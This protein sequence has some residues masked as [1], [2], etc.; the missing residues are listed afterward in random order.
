MGHKTRPNRSR[1]IKHIPYSLL[2]FLTISTIFATL[3]HLYHFDPEDHIPSPLPTSP[4]RP[5]TLP[6]TR[7]SIPTVDRK[8][9]YQ[10]CQNPSVYEH[11]QLHEEFC[12][13]RKELRTVNLQGWDST[14]KTFILTPENEQPREIHIDL[15]SLDTR[16]EIGYHLGL[17]TGNRVEY[18]RKHDYNYYFASTKL[19]N[20]RMLHPKFSKLAAVELLMNDQLEEKQWIVWMDNDILFTN[21][22]PRFEDLIEQYAHSETNLIITRDLR[23]DL[24]IINSGIFL[25]RNSAWSRTF[26][27]TIMNS[28]EARANS[29]LDEARLKDQPVIIKYLLKEGEIEDIREASIRINRHVSIITTRKMNSFC[30]PYI[31]YRWDDSSHSGSAIWHPGD[32]IAHF[33]GT[34]Q[35]TERYSAMAKL[36]QALPE[37]QGDWHLMDKNPCLSYGTNDQWRNRMHVFV[38]LCHFAVYLLRHS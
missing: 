19:P 2:K 15:L 17:L 38:I 29:R 26:I 14:T 6:G 16:N 11:L 4:I 23:Y 35:V 25:L 22:D 34:H 7:P 5:G 20:A 36:F 21:F 24:Q 18:A 9:H 3:F 30:R 31:R 32:F 27:S 10:S 33:T 12:I 13:H 28:P 37:A 8:I 1:Y